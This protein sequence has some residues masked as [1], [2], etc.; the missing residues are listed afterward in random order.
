MKKTM[1]LMLTATLLGF[2]TIASAATD[3]SHYSDKDLA[4]LRAKVCKAPIEDRMAYRHEW[5]KR[6]SELGPD[7]REHFNTFPEGRGGQCGRREEQCRMTGMQERLGLTDTQTV[8][9]KEMRE[10]HFT[11]MVAE[12]KELAALNRELEEESFKTNPDRKKIDDLSDRIGK[13]DASLAKLRSTHFT[14]LVSILTPPQR[15]KLQTLRDARE[16]RGH[17]QGHF[18]E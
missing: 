10:K 3:Y 12:K 2:G 1:M 11:L 6:L 4:G 8:K 18:C 14:E 17:H 13:K 7:P 9:V 16:L 15:T 5:Q